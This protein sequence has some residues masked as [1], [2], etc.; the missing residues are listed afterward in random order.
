MLENMPAE[1]NAVLTKLLSN[2]QLKADVSNY[3]ASGAVT[4]ELQ[5][6]LAALSALTATG[7]GST[8]P[9]TYAADGEAATCV[10][11]ASA[12][13]EE[14]YEEDEDARNARL[15]EQCRLEVEA[16]ISS[17]PDYAAVFAAAGLAAVPAPPATSAAPPTGSA[18][19]EAHAEMPVRDFLATLGLTQYVAA[20]EEDDVDLPTLAM[21][22]KR[23]GGPALDEALIELGVTSKGHRLK[24]RS[25]LS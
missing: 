16:L 6:E 21:V 9:A 14:L 11:A 17:K 25:A 22:Q 2:P 24:I 18:A 19:V 1:T 8:A 13:V 3:L 15:N 20:F 23:Q 4:P 10:S 12:K 7:G 5:R